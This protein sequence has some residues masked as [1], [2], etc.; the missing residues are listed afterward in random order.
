MATVTYVKYMKREDLVKM[1]TEIHRFSIIDKDGKTLTVDNRIEKPKYEKHD[2]YTICWHATAFKL[3]AFDMEDCLISGE[4]YVRYNSWLCCKR[5]RED[6]TQG[7]ILMD[8]YGFER[9]D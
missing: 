8:R 7:Q 4:G 1:L 5:M 9:E 2:T 6:T 3:N